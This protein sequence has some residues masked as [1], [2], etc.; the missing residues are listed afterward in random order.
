MMLKYYLSKKNLRCTAPNPGSNA[1][2]P[3]ICSEPE[4]TVANPGSTAPDPGKA[5]PR[6]AVTSNQIYVSLLL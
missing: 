2:D 4:T 5:S 3:G 1:P 6:P